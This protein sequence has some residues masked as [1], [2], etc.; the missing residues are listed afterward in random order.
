MT[1]LQPLSSAVSLPNS[2]RP[3]ISTSIGSDAASPPSLADKGQHQV[4]L[5]EEARFRTLRG[6]LPVK[7]LK[8]APNALSDS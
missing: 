3:F 4:V 8:A 6:G 2:G 5:E 7:R 1:Q